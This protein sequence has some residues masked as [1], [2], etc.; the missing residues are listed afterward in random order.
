[1]G[2][3]RW[4]GN[5]QAAEESFQAYKKL[6]P[7]KGTKAWKKQQEKNKRKKKNHGMTAKRYVAYLGSGWWKRR[8]IRALERAD[9]RCQDCQTTM[10]LIVHHLNYDHLWAERDKDLVVLCKECHADRHLLE[11]LNKIDPG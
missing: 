1:M 9:N 4:N 6:K 2:K 8:R 10:N 11:I 3:L 7:K 5:I